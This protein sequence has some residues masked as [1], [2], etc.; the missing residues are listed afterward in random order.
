MHTLPQ[1]SI[2]SRTLD[3]NQEIQC[4]VYY[5]AALIV[6]LVEK[7]EDRSNTKKTMEMSKN[8]MQKVEGK[9]FTNSL[10]EKTYPIIR[11]T[12]N[13]ETILYC[14]PAAIAGPKERGLKLPQNSFV[15]ILLPWSTKGGK[16]QEMC[17]NSKAVK[18]MG[19]IVCQIISYTESKWLLDLFMDKVDVVLSS[20][21]VS[22]RPLKNVE[23]FHILSPVSNNIPF[24]VNAMTIG[25]ETFLTVASAHEKLEAADLMR[26]VVSK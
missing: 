2:K 20:L 26:E 9:S 18:L 25:T 6:V 11:S 23:S 24:T 15:P 21:M 4:L 8:T 22:D 1:S 3:F 10:I 5:L 17:L 19:W 14:I 16:I 13:K 12:L 7:K